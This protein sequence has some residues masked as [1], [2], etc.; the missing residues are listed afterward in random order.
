MK[1]V[2]N[3]QVGLTPFSLREGP[4]SFLKPDEKKDKIQGWFECGEKRGNQV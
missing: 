3:S 1:E 4:F 2:N